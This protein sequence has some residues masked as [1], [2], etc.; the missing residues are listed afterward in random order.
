MSR[1]KIHEIILAN[2]GKR[3]ILYTTHY[4]DEADLADSIAIISKGKLQCKGSPAALKSDLGN[5][6]KIITPIPI[7]GMREW[8]V[9]CSADVG[10]ILRVIEDHGV[11]NYKVE[12]PTLE[13]V[14]LNVVANAKAIEEAAANGISLDEVVN[15]NFI[16][17]QDEPT[18]APLNLS[19][20]TH[21]NFWREM[22]AI[23][24]KRWMIIRRSYIPV[25]AVILIPIAVAFASRGLLE[26]YKMDN[27]VRR[28]PTALHRRALDFEDIGN[29][30]GTDLGNLTGTE[31]DL[32]N[33]TAADL[34]NLTIGNLTGT[35]DLSTPS[36]E[37]INLY[38]DQYLN[39]KV[40]LA[41]QS[42]WGK[43]Q[44]GAIQSV[45]G[46]YALLPYKVYEPDLASYE[47]QV[48]ANFQTIPMALYYDAVGNKSIIGIN[49]QLPITYAAMPMNI[50]N[51]VRLNQ[52]GSTLKISQPL[53]GTISGNSNTPP[54]LGWVM[55]FIFFFG[56]AMAV[57]AAFPALYPTY[58]FPMTFQVLS[59]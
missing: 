54:G 6:Y 3:T 56:F 9:S 4:L 46:D 31:V 58:I 14:F 25:I 18:P 40:L 36:Q 23:Y 7:A 45:A 48:K 24:F 55:I 27:C 57:A 51:T 32:S 8:L 35:S 41:P 53:V 29:L 34:E 37:E 13:Q 10:P 12:A 30:G 49:M 11:E 38:Y 59:S 2:R 1:L 42:N 50:M 5:G 17:V 21:S 20:S 22:A 52:S 43:K 33:L 26:G 28:N 39:N 47:A 19:S 15:S 44:I 16:R